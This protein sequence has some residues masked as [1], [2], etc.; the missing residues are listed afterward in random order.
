MVVMSLS[1]TDHSGVSHEATA[2]SPTI[3]L[4]APHSLAPQPKCGPVMPS[5]PRRISR[6]D[7]SGSASTS[8]STP[9]TRNRILG[10]ENETLLRDL[11]RFAAELL[12]DLGPFHNIAAQKFVEFFRRHRHRNRALVGPEFDDVRPLDYRVYRGVE[13]VDNRFW[14]L[15]GRH[16]SEPD[17]RLVSGDAGLRGC[18]HIW[19]HAG[20][21]LAGSG[22]RAHLVLADIGGHRR[23]R[24]DHHL[25]LSADDAA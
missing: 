8:V 9:L 24:V 4:Q 2:C 13:L 15:R 14:C 20:T 10:I 17:G 1:A 25:H 16:Q 3:T 5:S 12:D 21:R 11:L 19:Q 7:E 6:S 23:N 18:R 22:E